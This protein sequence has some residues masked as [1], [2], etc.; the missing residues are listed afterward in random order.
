LANGG[1]KRREVAEL[2]SQVHHGEDG[3][4]TVLAAITFSQSLC[5]DYCD[6]ICD[7]IEVCWERYKD[8]DYVEH[9]GQQIL[10]NL[11]RFTKTRRLV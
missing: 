2:A 9:G 10:L 11:N 3:A 4:T 7:I 1:T 6:R 8:P 5:A